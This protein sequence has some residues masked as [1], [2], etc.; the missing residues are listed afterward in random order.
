HPAPNEYRAECLP[1]L[2]SVAAYQDWDALYLHEYG[3]FKTGGDANDRVQAY[4]VV[5]SDPAK[6]AFLPAAAMLFRAG[7]IAPATSR[8]LANVPDQPAP[9]T[10]TIDKLWQGTDLANAVLSRRLALLFGPRPVNRLTLG[11]TWPPPGTAT[12]AVAK[13]DPK[14][15][16]YTADA[17]AAKVVAG[18]VAGQ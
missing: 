8:A 16:R 6:W 12:L 5:G 17:P 7:A 13:T 2:A 4:F 1:L 15:A 9:G 14:T 18:F 11:A 3:W 10:L